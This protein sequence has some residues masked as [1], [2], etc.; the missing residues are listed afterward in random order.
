MESSSWSGCRMSIPYSVSVLFL[1]DQGSDLIATSWMV[2]VG[3]SD[4]IEMEV[5]GDQHRECVGGR[6]LLFLSIMYKLFDLIVHQDTTWH[7]NSFL[8]PCHLTTL[9]HLPHIQVQVL[10]LYSYAAIS[11]AFILSTSPLA[12]F[13]INC[14]VLM[15]SKPFLVLMRSSSALTA[16]CAS[17][18]ASC[19]SA[20]DSGTSVHL[21]RCWNQ[22][23]RAPAGRL[24][25]GRETVRVEIRPLVVVDVVVIGIGCCVSSCSSAD[26]GVG[27]SSL[28]CDVD[29]DC[30][31]VGW[32]SIRNLG[33]GINSFFGSVT[34]CLKACSSPSKSRNNLHGGPGFSGVPFSAF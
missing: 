34:S 6:P 32:E 25:T 21:V 16:C 27:I 15:V 18:S 9:T 1:S 4:E 30:D 26:E 10:Y 24:R 8:F 22:N 11:S 29:R 28:V 23:Q 12:I 33:F 20:A 31:R 19:L 5:R 17:S 2:R 3:T 14:C 13:S 7:G